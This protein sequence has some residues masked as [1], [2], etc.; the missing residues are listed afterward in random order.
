M[1]SYVVRI[2]RRNA[3]APEKILGII[4][5]VGS[6]DKK[7]FKNF[8]ELWMALIFPHRELGPKKSILIDAEPDFGH[9]QSPQ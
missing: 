8:D 2:Y 1:E 5:E 3:G 4:E 6:G 7:T 9:A